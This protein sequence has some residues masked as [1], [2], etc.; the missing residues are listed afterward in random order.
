[1]PLAIT[2]ATP[3]TLTREKLAI[4]IDAGLISIRMGIESAAKETKKFYKRPSS[5][6]QVLKAARLLGEYG[7]YT[8]IFYNII[9]IFN[10]CI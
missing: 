10:S 9:L 6:I 3:S 1:M 5:N 2:G 4:L 7:N 8:K